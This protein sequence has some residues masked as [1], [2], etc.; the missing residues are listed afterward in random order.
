MADDSTPL[1]HLL[2]D[3][4]RNEQPVT[5]ITV[6]DGPGTGN[7]LLVTPDHQPLGT[8][9]H[10][11]LD[12]IAARAGANKRM[13]YYYFGNKDALFLA[14]LKAS[15]GRIRAAERAL[16][17][18]DLNDY[19]TPFD[20]PDRIDVA[21]LTKMTRWMYQTGR[22]VADA[23]KRPAVDPAFKLERCRDFTGDYCGK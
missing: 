1:F 12:R 9:G 4:I 22:T 7:K 14:V 10:T 13:L 15:Y 3:L 23:A 6:V 5:L 8:L 17:L 21:K 11:E 20:N 18:E 2:R 16:R 19:H